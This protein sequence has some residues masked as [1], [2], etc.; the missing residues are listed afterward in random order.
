MEVLVFLV[1]LVMGVNLA[2]NILTRF[3]ACGIRKNSMF[4]FLFP[5]FLRF[6]HIAIFSLAIGSRPQMAKAE[7]Q[8]C[9]LVFPLSF[10]D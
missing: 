10:Q 5:F 4:L 6:A 3:L 9:D 7:M 8:G 2:W 1:V